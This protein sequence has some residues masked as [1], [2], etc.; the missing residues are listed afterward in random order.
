MKNVKIVFLGCLLSA[1]LVLAKSELSSTEI[2]AASYI[3]KQA[4]EPIRVEENIEIVN[5]NV[6]E[7]VTD[8]NPNQPTQ[9]PPANNPDCVQF[10]A[11]LYPTSSERFSAA[12]AC[13][14]VYSIDCVQF[15]AGTYPAFIQREAAARS[16]AGVTDYA[17]VT[18]VAGPYPTASQRIEAAKA[19]RYASVDCVRQVAGSFPNYSQK[20]AA[21]KACGGQ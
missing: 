9:P 2:R 21:A 4:S 18:F 10:V 1:N 3:L 12:R 16:C 14:G 17:C 7:H 5:K 8:C 19:C 15:A 6:L 13:A 11:G 20:L